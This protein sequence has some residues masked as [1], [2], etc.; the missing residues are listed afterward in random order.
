MDNPRYAPCR[1][2]LEHSV[3]SLLWFEDAIGAYDVPT[4]VFDLHLIV[5]DIDLAAA[6]FSQKGW[7]PEPPGLYT[8]LL[9]PCAMQFSQ[10]I[11]PP[12]QNDVTPA[13]D[14]NYL[15][16]QEK[17]PRKRMV[18]VLMSAVE[19]GISTEVLHDASKNN[20][21][22][23]TLPVLTNGLIRKLLDAPG[24]S[25]VESHLLTM[26]AYLYGHSLELKAEGFEHQLDLEH[27]QFHLDCISGQ[28]R[29]WTIPFAQHERQVREA[30]RAGNYTFRDCSTTRTEENR[31][32][33]DDLF[34]LIKS[35]RTHVDTE[36]ENSDA[37]IK[38]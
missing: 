18:I 20:H 22:L 9:P 16:S 29:L 17:P 19:W 15:N 37:I 28:L 6:V 27:Q 35:R 12:L 8:F 5:P 2:L 21:F 33:F 24:D 32:L 3:P 7:Q 11:E 14:D 13:Q 36:G 38:N 10:L 23:P 30:I 25:S 26:L 34:T 1:I 4:V 31:P